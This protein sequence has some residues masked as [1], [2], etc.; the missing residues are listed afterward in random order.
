MAKSLV[1]TIVANIKRRADYNITDSDLDSLIIDS[2]NDNIQLLANILWDNN[3]TED[4]TNSNTL[5]TVPLQSWVDPTLAILTGNCTAFTAIAGDTI[6]VIIDG[7]TQN[8]VLTG[9]TSI[10]DVATAINTAFGVSVASVDVNG[11]LCISSQTAGSTSAVT[12]SNVVGTPAT[13]LFNNTTILTG[14]INTYTPVAGDSMTVIIDSVAYVQAMAGLT[15]IA[16][17]AAAINTTVGSTVADVSS[18]GYLRIRSLTSGATANVSVMN[19]VGGGTPVNR[20]FAAQPTLQQLAVL[21]IDEL[22]EA[23]ERTYKYSLQIIPYAQLIEMYPDPT[24]ITAAVPDY[25]ARWDNRLYF[26]PT[27]NQAILIYL[28]YQKH[29]SNVALGGTMPFDQSLDSI[30]IS[31][32]RADI[33]EWLDPSNVGAVQL[34]RAKA[35]DLIQQLIIDCAKNVRMNRQCTSRRNTIPYFSPR[36]VMTPAIS[37]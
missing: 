27:P 7:T 17:I 26:A 33:T 21:D 14:N 19:T 22:L 28:D 1:N 2:L 8:V 35:K 36:K 31:S 6:R 4:I 10:I 30:L 15:T 25:V 20:L 16:L 13:R 5:R 32:T 23:S 3:L 34:A 11:Y 24:A 9:S 29:I 37:S 12:V 18:G